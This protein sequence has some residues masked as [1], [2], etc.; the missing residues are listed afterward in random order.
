MGVPPISLPHEETGRGGDQHILGPK[1]RIVKGLP[2][3]GPASYKVEA[4]QRLYSALMRDRLDLS[5]DLMYSLRRDVLT[6][7]F[8]YRTGDVT[9]HC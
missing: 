3:L 4:R 8:R 2:P 7:P 5:L 9:Q 1:P 6:V